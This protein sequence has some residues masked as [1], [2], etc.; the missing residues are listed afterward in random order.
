MQRA[1]LDVASNAG[2]CIHVHLCCEHVRVLSAFAKGFHSPFES[3]TNA[4]TNQL[5]FLN[6][7]ESNS[8]DC[9]Q[10]LIVCGVMVLNCICNL[11]AIHITEPYCRI[12]RSI[13]TQDTKKFS[14]STNPQVCSLIDSLK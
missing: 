12:H 10:L 3:N 5:H 14:F 13:A 2:S 8:T 6:E 4:L 11:Y 1:Q 7:I 9:M